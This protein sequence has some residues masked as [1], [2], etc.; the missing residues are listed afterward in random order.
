VLADQ[1]KSLDWQARKAELIARAP[2]AVVQEVL[3]RIRTLV[4]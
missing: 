2:A 3:A 4:T 1:I